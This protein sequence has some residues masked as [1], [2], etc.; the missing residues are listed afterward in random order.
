MAVLL[1]AGYAGYLANTVVNLPTNVETALIAQGL[2]TASTVASTTTGAVTANVMQGTCAVAAASGASITI[3][4]NKVD[5]NSIV[6]AVVAQAAADGTWL[7]VERVVPAAGSFTIYGTAAATATTL[8]DWA[9]LS[10]SIGA[11]PL[12]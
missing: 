4:N 7:R 1:N 9:V 10:P 2:A 3:T 12:N 5:A 6:Y 8:I 11:Y